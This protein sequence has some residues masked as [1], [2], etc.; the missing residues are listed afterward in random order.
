VWI[1]LKKGMLP[2]KM[3]MYGNTAVHQAAAAGNVKVLECFLNWGIDVKEEN[4]R[5]HTPMDLATEPNTK[6]LLQKALK[7]RKCEKCKTEFDIK[8]FPHYCSQSGKFYCI[9]CSK[10]Q[11]VYETWESEETERLVCRSLEVE[12]KINAK[13]DDLSAAIDSYDYYN[14]DKS[15]A[16]CA[17][18]DI[19]VKLRKKA[20]VLHL[21]LQHELKISTF[22]K[23]K[24]HHDNYKDIRKDVQRITE[25][26]EQA[27]NLEIDLEP[28][29]IEGVNAFTFRLISE[30]NLRK[31]RD[32]YLESI[33]SCD[34]DKVSKLQSLINTADENKVENEY[35]ATAKTL[36]SQ[37][38][39]NI[40]A[41]ETLQML[42]DYPEREYPEPEEIDPKKKDKKAPP[43]KK[44]K[45][46][47]NFPTPEWAEELDA[48]IKKVNEMQTLVQDRENLKLD[49]E[50]IGKVT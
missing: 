4:A 9:N 17:G 40:K 10:I 30:R 14:L 18:Y 46:A 1:L 34:N 43:K 2:K 20:E 33:Q 35:I 36:T 23:E 25:M 26:V 48:V 45:K 41:R 37:M 27:Q 29:L 39:G 42:L 44:K 38:S 8:N 3:D 13:E 15:L 11:W 21:K 6:Q 49:D 16:A 28:T 22:M 5:G 19:A 24:D 12:D 50:F 31:Q 7:A 47:D 32:L